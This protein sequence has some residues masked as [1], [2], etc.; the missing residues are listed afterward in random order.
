MQ[1][2]ATT[3]TVRTALRIE[4]ACFCAAAIVLYAKFGLA[5]WVF[6]VLF[7]APDLAFFAYLAGPRLGS[8][9][10]NLLHSWSGPVLCLLAG[11]ILHRPILTGLSL[12]WCAHIGFDRALGY[13]LK[14]AEGFGYTHLGRMGRGSSPCD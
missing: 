3:G 10:Y 4:G 12:I 8:I 2:G 14:Y 9:T 7:L 11:W 6:A 1:S 5:W 13:G